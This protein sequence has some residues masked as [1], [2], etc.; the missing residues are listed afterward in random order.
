MSLPR[1]GSLETF[2][3]VPQEGERSRRGSIASTAP[4]VTIRP[5]RISFNP[6]P[7]SWDPVIPEG[8][9]DNLA[10]TVGAFEVPQWKRILQIV[11]AVIYCF[12]AAGVVFG[13]AAIKPV[14]KKTG[15]YREICEGSDT[16]VE[17]RLNL[18][19]TVAAVA[20]NVVA[21]PVGAILDHF[22]PQ[23][24]GILGA[25]FLA[26]GSC[27][28]AFAESVSFDAFLPGY[29][30][31]ALGGPF[32]YISSFQLS[33]AFP[34]SSGLILA[35]LTGAFDASSA[36]FLLYRVIFQRTDGAFGLQKFFLA[37]LAVPAMIVVMQLTIL[38]KQSYKTVGEMMTDYDAPTLSE[39]FHSGSAI[40]DDQIDEETALL[41]EQ[42]QTSHNQNIAQE[43]EELLGSGTADKQAHREEAANNK[44]GVWG[45]MHNHPALEQ[46]K[47]PWFILIC[48]F[49]VVQMTRI[50]YFVATIRTQ[51][52]AILGSEEQAME[53]NYFFDLALPL[54][55]IISI[56]FIG[57]ILDHTSTIAVLAT[58]VTVATTIGVLGV[59]PY[60]WAAYANVCLFVLYRPFYY[61]AVSD[62][63]AKV[64]GFR[65]FGTVY[66]LI[67]CLAG[68]LNFSQSG[69][70]YLFHET[71]NEDPVP[72]NLI[73]LSLGL[74]IGVF[75]VGFV[76]LKARGFKM[77]REAGYLGPGEY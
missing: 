37:Y 45:V 32:T 17:M 42:S 29:L 75:L 41:R 43:I 34:R 61:T 39:P 58:L 70:D 64:F 69:L 18:M 2:L 30:F 71:F 47:S 60:T 74:I 73:L 22:G 7:E 11:C 27:F 1:V 20:T 5:Q 21:L 53:I 38:P 50:N 4:S 31:L 14:L 76:T 8:D 63:S 10:N 16:C 67:I 66:G 9:V 35:L 72:V 44:S 33:N 56:P 62:Y 15:A 13:Y 19:F 23:V 52:T 54:G 46:I 36:L 26:I 65:T 12:F 6:L 77:K 3:S 48:L 28:M 40:A 55:G 24:C 57:G 25:V 51:Y 68:L 49:T 59:L